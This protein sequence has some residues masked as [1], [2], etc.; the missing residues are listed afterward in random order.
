MLNCPQ[1]GHETPEDQFQEGYCIHCY[2]DNQRALDEHN[3]QYDWWNSLSDYDRQQ[4]IKY[5][6]RL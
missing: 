3:A 2:A 6:A 4:H 5:A 1:C